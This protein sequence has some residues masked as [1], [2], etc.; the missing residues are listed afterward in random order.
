MR[1]KIWLIPLALLLIV[2]LVACA[3]PAPVP[4]TPAPTTVTA[5]AA[6]VTAPAATVTA[7]AATVTAPVPTAE[8]P[9]YYWRMGHTKPV[10]H[11][12]DLAAHWLADRINRDSDGRIVIDIFPA[13]ALG[14]YTVVQ[15]RVSLGAIETNFSCLSGMVDQRLTISGL[16]YVSKSW[17]DVAQVY[18][19][20]TFLSDKISEFL[21]DQNIQNV[22]VWLS[23]FGGMSLKSMP[24]G[25]GDP[26]VFKDCK[27]RVPPLKVFEL[28][29][30]LFGYTATPMPFTESFA[31][32]QTGMIG[33]VFGA[34]ADS[35]YGYFRDYI[36]C[37]VQYNDHFE[38][39]HTYMNMD[40]W[41]SLSE[42]DKDIILNACADLEE[43]RALEGIQDEAGY[44][45]KLEDYGIET[46]TLTN[47]ELSEFAK[48]ARTVIWP[49]V[50]DIIGRDVVDRLVKDLESRER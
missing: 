50:S 15:E 33:G 1:K 30:E 48:R 24:E 6:T 43:Q 7:P 18:G 34:G 12:L 17:D 27:V 13:N 19:T 10:G 44:M 45:K 22:G 4:T 38:D 2:S 3:A 21:G 49:Q 41:K 32:L 31:A 11:A 26:D 14:D 35:A 28:T 47:E 29:A 39:Y 23:H 9:S 46:V 5:P 16:P 8:G 42:Q 36:K 40:L 20:G 37:Y 25:P